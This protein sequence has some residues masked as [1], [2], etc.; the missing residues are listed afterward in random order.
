MSDIVVSLTNQ[1]RQ[2]EAQALLYGYG[3]Q[4]STFVIGSGGSDPGDP[5]LALPL[6]LNADTL[7]GQ[8]YGPVEIDNAAL[9]S[10]TCPQWTCILQPGE[11]VGNVSNIGLIATVVFIPEA[12]ILLDPSAVNPGDSDQI[13]SPTQINNPV[14]GFNV[15]N[16]GFE[17]GDVV[18]F[19][20]AGTLPAPLNNTTQYYVVFGLPGFPNSFQVSNSLSGTPITLTS[21]GSG[22]GTVRLASDDTFTY[23]NHGL[24]NGDAVTM[25]TTGTMPGGLIANTVYYVVNAT[26]NT[27][28][29][30]LT[31]NGPSIDFTSTGTGVLTV[32]NLNSIPPGAPTVGS[33]FL[34]CI[35]NFPLQVKLASV[36]QTY[37]LTLQT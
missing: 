35:A 9:I 23:Q 27:F 28:Q 10:P 31:T 3:Y 5:T 14:A 6:N 30:S 2:M 24:V 13:F 17:N 19:D 37:T 18:V 11:A 21:S 1:A 7:P 25:I 33:T 16:H 20:S 4:I 15:Q 32:T 12:S 34:Y 29:I 22:T 8:F 26:T 36:Q